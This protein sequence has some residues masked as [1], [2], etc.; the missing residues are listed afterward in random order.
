M[1][2]GDSFVRRRSPRKSVNSMRLWLREWLGR[3]WH[4][5]H[6]IAS[7]GR[8]KVNN[9]LK[10]DYDNQSWAQVNKLLATYA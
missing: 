3:L 8:D 4:A 2:S 10:N 5:N 6:S 9:E 1:N 7:D